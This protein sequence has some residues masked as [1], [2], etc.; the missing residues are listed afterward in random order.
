[1]VGSVNASRDHFQL[2]VDDLDEARARWPGHTERLITGQRPYGEFA[3]ALSRHDPDE[4]KVTL[5]WGR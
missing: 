5:E 2:A 4:I 1:M 3:A